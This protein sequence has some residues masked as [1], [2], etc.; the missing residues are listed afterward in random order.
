MTRNVF[1]YGSLMFADVWG[2]VVAG[3][4]RP[5]DASLEHHAR[6]AI[7]GET[8]PGMVA[9][10]D[11]RVAG[12]VYLDVDADDLERLDRFEGDDYRREPIVVACADG[13]TRPADTYVYRRVERLLEA[14]W[15]PDAFAMQRFIETYCRDR[16]DR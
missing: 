16:L 4:Y 9:L 5:I 12:V 3:G 8:Y 7:A 6:F 13:T 2:R 10:R 14:P 11:A 1:T 15:E